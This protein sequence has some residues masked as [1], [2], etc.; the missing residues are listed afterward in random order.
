MLTPYQYTS[1]NPIQNIDIDGLE[2]GAA[3]GANTNTEAP[4][5]PWN[6][7]FLKGKKQSYHNTSWMGWP[8]STK[9]SVFAKNVV[10]SAWNQ[11]VFAAES[12]PENLD[13]ITSKHSKQENF[14]MLINLT[15][16]AVRWWNSK[17][18]QKVETYEDIGGSILLSRV[19]ST[20]IS[21]LNVGGANRGM[22]GNI[23]PPAIYPGVGESTLLNYTQGLGSRMFTR[24]TNVIRGNVGE[25]NS[26]Y[27]WTIDERGINIALETTPPPVV[28][29]RSGLIKHT[30]ISTTAYSGGEVWFTGEKSVYIIPKSARF[31]GSSMT[32]EQWNAAKTAWEKIGY[33]VEAADFKPPSK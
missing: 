25:A 3:N 12:L 33:K 9:Q 14:E 29:T 8:G 10:T 26:K 30:N 11:R 5:G 7:E 32:T 1:N 15:M 22:V 23:R 6:L 19:V 18:L 13:Y 24:F 16:K 28:Q 21:K 20:G 17:P 27:L 31:G 4:A 2:G